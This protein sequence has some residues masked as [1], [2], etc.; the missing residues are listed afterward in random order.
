MAV[1]E[2]GKVVVWSSVEDGSIKQATG[3][4]LNFL[5][6]ATDSTVGEGYNGIRNRSYLGL[7]NVSGAVIRTYKIEN[8]DIYQAVLT[9]GELVRVKAN[10]VGGVGKPAYLG[11]TGVVSSS[12]AVI[13]GEFMGSVSNGESNIR[14]IPSIVAGTTPAPDPVADTQSGKNKNIDNLKKENIDNA[15]KEN[16]VKNV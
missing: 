13:I 15:K 6:I 7:A 14:V 16:E 1:I 10:G 3:S 12:G 5:G 4:E 9:A 8:E 2:A 11:L